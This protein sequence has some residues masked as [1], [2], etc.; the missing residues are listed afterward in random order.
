M[1]NKIDQFWEIFK[2]VAGDTSADVTESTNAIAKSD[3]TKV[4]SYFSNV[5]DQYSFETADYNRLRKFLIDLYATHRTQSTVS[6]SSTDPHALTNSD[7]DELFRSMGYDLSSSLRGFDENPL[8]QKVQFFLDLVN[9]YKVKGTPQS[10]VDVLQYYGVT[11]VDIFEFFLKKDAPDSLF[12]DGKAVAGTT[13]NPSGIALPYNSLT[14]TDPHWLYTAQQILQLDQINKIN[15]PSK[16]PYLGVQ[17]VVD[18][19]G[20]E[21]AIINRYVQDQYDY[22]E[23][24]GT[25]PPP[26]AEIT[27]IGETRSLLELYLSCIYMFNKLFDVGSDDP[28]RFMCYDGTNIDNEVEIIAE[29]EDLTQRKV[30]SRLDL[31]T[32]YEQYLGLFSRPVAENFLINE[33]TA[34][35]ELNTIAPD[36]KAAL[37]AA[38]EPLEVLYSLLKDLALWVRA[39]IGFGFVNFGFILFGIQEFFKDLKPVID[40]FKPYRARLLLL[41]NLQA[42]NR[43]FNSIII[44]DS[45]SVD[46]DFEF[47]DYLTGD[48]SPCCNTDDSTCVT[49]STVCQREFI[50][51]TPPSYNWK[52]FWATGESYAIDDAVASGPSR[53][54]ICIQAHTSGTATKPGTGADW[55][56]YWQLMSTIECTDSTADVS[57]YSRETY[58]CGSYYDIGAVTDIR[59]DVNIEVEQDHHDHLRCPAADGTGFVVSELTG[60]EYTKQYTR[61]FIQGSSTLSVFFD[62]DMPNTNYSIAV[63]IGFDISQADPL[64][65]TPTPE[66]FAVIVTDKQTAKF[67]V[68]LSSPVPNNCYYVDWYA[69][70]DTSS[71]VVS[72]DT[73]GLTFTV[74]V[75][76]STTDYVVA[77]SIV[78]NVDVAPSIYGY[79]ISDKTTTSFKVTLSGVPDSP[80][81]QFEYAVCDADKRGSEVIGVGSDTVSVTFTYPIPH[82]EYPVTTLIESPSGTVYVP[83]ISDKTETGFTV[84]L[85][86]PADAAN[87]KLIWSVPEERS[88]GIDSIDYY[89]TGGFRDFDSEGT[90]DCTHGFDLVQITVE[91]V[92]AFLLQETGFYL[93]QEDGFRILL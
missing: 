18:L 51:G 89:Q 8:E 45:A 61:Y 25:V 28:T 10:L 49:G 58:D 27:F 41:E 37:D 68:T 75:N 42:K 40:F 32:R 81:Y 82:P 65:P 57:Y 88:Y 6:L 20:A 46:A 17:P 16:T 12:F 86:S 24:H 60:V 48:S 66:Q 47:H 39:N 76:C 90:F 70:D 11:E 43:L 35:N 29:F 9:L 56:L 53:Q 91:D 74:P 64:L 1:A 22:Y 5:I 3:R 78:N 55:T 21:M 85:S 73:T 59:Q 87:F 80:N 71:Q 79:T 31:K 72:I 63:S 50:G 36:I 52:D 7:L 23:A 15:L 26:D 38:G 2:A 77:G 14:S 30:E 34:G 62:E 33:D 69:Y 44:E 13:I 19:E 92:Y 4:E 67:D 93:L 54:Y 83:V 84:E